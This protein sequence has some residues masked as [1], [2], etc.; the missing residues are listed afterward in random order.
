VGIEA[1]IDTPE[2]GEAADHQSRSRE[3][4]KGERHFHHHENALGAMP[5]AAQPT[6]SLL[7]RFLKIGP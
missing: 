1:G 5:G 3:K 7:E 2:L 6:P 4:D